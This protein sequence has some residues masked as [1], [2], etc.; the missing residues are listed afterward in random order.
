MAQEQY[1]I[2]EP[3][4]KLTSVVPLHVLGP[5]LIGLLTLF[6]L[7]ILLQKSVK[8]DIYEPIEKPVIKVEEVS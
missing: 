8:Q 1:M 2:P 5:A 6:S 7:M 4:Q 3:L